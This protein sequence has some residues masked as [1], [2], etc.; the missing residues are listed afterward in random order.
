MTNTQ[1]RVLV[2]AIGLLAGVVAAHADYLKVN[3]GLVN[4]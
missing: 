4:G 3:V 2:A 1:I